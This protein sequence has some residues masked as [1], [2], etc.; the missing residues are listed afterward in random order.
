M[1]PVFDSIAA[2][3][4]CDIGDLGLLD[5]V[6]CDVRRA[7]A[8]V[9][10][11]DREVHLREALCDLVDGGLGLT[12]DADHELVLAREIGQR[13]IHIGVIDVLDHLHLDLV[14]ILLLCG[15]QPVEGRLHPSLVG[16]RSRNQ[17]ADLERIGVSGIGGSASAPVEQRGLQ[18]ETA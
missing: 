5:I 8:F 3:A 6:A 17:D 4:P 16:L 11:D 1:A 15:C 9:A 10:A 7:L 14:A 2:A 13:L 12:A 18:N